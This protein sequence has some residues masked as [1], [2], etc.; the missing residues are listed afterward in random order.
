MFAFSLDTD[1]NET[2]IITYIDEVKNLENN[3][4]SLGY[5]ELR[6]INV[7]DVENLKDKSSEK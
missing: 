4:T 1:E 2:Q 6:L 5:R 3:R 7:Y